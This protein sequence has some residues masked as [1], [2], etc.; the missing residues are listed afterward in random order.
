[1]AAPLCV[2]LD[3]P[4]HR[5]Q[6][7]P[8]T[9]RPSSRFSRPPQ[10]GAFFLFF[11]VSACLFFAT[12]RF[13]DTAMDKSSAHTIPPVEHLAI[14]PIGRFPPAVSMTSFPKES[15]QPVLSFSRL[16]S[17]MR[18]VGGEDGGAHMSADLCAAQHARSARALLIV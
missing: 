8:V 16:P 13:S 1:V 18:A 10:I 6:W 15:I 17:S 7:R 11:T 9:H 14:F 3:A 4:R 2:S 5:A 12:H